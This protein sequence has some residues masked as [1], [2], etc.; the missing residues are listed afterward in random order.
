MS[1]SERVLHATRDNQQNLYSAVGT[2]HKCETYLGSCEEGIAKGLDLTICNSVSVVCP[3]LMLIDLI[4]SMYLHIYA[5][6]GMS[7]M[8]QVIRP[9]EFTVP[10]I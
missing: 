3:P 10:M 5:D 9:I 4:S 2:T 1:G 7:S 8:T 6:M